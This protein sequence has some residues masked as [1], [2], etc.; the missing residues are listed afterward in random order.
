[1]VPLGAGPVRIR[2]IVQLAGGQART[3]PAPDLL[4]R[5]GAARR[6]LDRAAAGGTRI[7]GLNTGLG[8]K[9]GHDL[10]GYPNGLEAAAFQTLL[11]RGR[12]VAMGLPLPTRTV[13]AAMAAR[14]AMLS[15]GG[16][17]ISPA[18]FTALAALLDRAVHPRVPRHGSQGESDLCLFAHVALVL[19]GEGEAEYQGRVLPGGRALEEAGLE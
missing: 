8:A 12:A 9:V 13:R 6:A 1:M 3:A 18:L 7:Y 15:Q 17:G 11:V 14:L 5:L 2:D 4:E 16:S 10:T 19:I